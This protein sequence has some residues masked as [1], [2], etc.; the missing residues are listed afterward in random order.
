MLH[1]DSGYESSSPKP[2]IFLVSSRCL[3]SVRVVTLWKIPFQ[4]GFSPRSIQSLPRRS[5]RS[6]FHSPTCLR[7]KN[8][9]PLLLLQQWKLVSAFRTLCHLTLHGRWA[10]GTCKCSTVQYV[11]GET[12][13]RALQDTFLLRVHCLIFP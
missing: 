9:W 11:K 8:M 1:T 12:A 13:F 2:F 7:R 6:G 5:L 3:N 10:T 4:N